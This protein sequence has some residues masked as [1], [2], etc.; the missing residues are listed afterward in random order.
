LGLPTGYQW[1]VRS[2]N[3]YHVWFRCEEEIVF[4]STPKTR[5]VGYARNPSDAPFKQLELRL[6]DC[7]TLLPPSL[8]PEGKRYEW[9]NGVPGWGV[10]TVPVE[11]VESAFF[12]IA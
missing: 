4:N 8:H 12:S 11:L 10:A 5:Y 2:G 7:Y 9:V 3:G 6:E 1:V